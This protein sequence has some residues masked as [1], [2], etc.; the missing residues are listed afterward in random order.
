MDIEPAEEAPP[1]VPNLAMKLDMTMS[2]TSTIEVGAADEQGRVEARITY[3]DVTFETTMNGQPAPMPS[4]R[5]QIA[6]RA[7]TIVYDRDGQMVD[8]KADVPDAMFIT[9]KPMMSNMFGATGSLRLAVGETVTRTVEFPLPVPNGGAM[10]T[11]TFQILFTLTS[12]TLEGADH[13]AHLTTALT[14]Q[15]NPPDTPASD[16]AAAIAMRMTGTGTM[17]VNVERGV[18]KSGE[19]RM[20]IDATIQGSDPTTPTPGMRM[21]GTVKVS[22]ATVP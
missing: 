12:V 17:D 8:F 13:I 1:S 14:S 2:M 15:M 3:D 11:P 5:D 18:V 7:M 16:A 9:L 10:G 20:T 19:Q 21:H 22:Q 4:P 6:G